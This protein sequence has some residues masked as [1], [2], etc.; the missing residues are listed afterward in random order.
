MLVL[1]HPTRRRVKMLPENLQTQNCFDHV[2]WARKE[3]KL[4]VRAR[5]PVTGMQQDRTDMPSHLFSLEKKS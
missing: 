3:V 5:A 2:T 1:N 4:F